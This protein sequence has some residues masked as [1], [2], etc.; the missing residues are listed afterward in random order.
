MTEQKWRELVEKSKRGNTAALEA[1]YN[2]TKRSVYFTA[3]KMLAN[4]ENAKDVMQ[5]TFMTA[6][7]KLNDLNDGANFPK[8]VNSIA[9][10]KCRRYFR[11]PAADSLDE[12]LEQGYEIK[13]DESFIPEEY[14][15]NEV[16]RRVVM[17]IITNSLSDVQRQTIIMY[18][19]DGL[20]LEY[21]ARVMG[22]PVKTVSS[23]LCSA[24]EKIRE[25]VL[26][27]EKKQGDRLH[28][29]VPVPILAVILRMEAEKLSVPD[30]PFD[31]LA[32]ALAAAVSKTAAA[33]AASGTAAG[34]SA[35]AKA[36]GA[37]A[38]G[39][40]A[41]TKIISGK[42]IAGVLAVAIT[43]GGITAAV[44]HTRNK[45]KQPTVS[46]TVAAQSVPETVTSE[47]ASEPAEPTGSSEP[48]VE[49]NRELNDEMKAR[50]EELRASGAET[51]ETKWGTP[52][53][54]RFKEF[55]T[56]EI[57]EVRCN[58]TF[59]Y[60]PEAAG[61]MDAVKIKE[62]VLDAMTLVIAHRSGYMDTEHL[63]GESL[64]MRDEVIAMLANEHGILL[65]KLAIMSLTTL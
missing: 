7:E 10:N 35:A 54:V 2:E 61:D 28:A 8:W 15:S 56:G 22:C 21:I 50:L 14:V 59:V 34:T 43:G 30:I 45:D 19:Y 3:L 48:Y 27:Y 17:D 65:D 4:E 53:P 20:S 46:T 39:G 38:K 33:G 41:V 24:R 52:A 12:Q 47:A 55:S 44:V 26:I 32:K 62:Y 64:K 23:R 57:S 49:L 42:I 29:V 51:I 40:A 5:D 63:P 37:A 13:D 11:K 6:I 36:A 9:V 58:G 25:A 18:Y 1:L 16:K 60:F 31:V